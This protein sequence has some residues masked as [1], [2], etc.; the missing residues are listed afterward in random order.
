MIR[1]GIIGSGNIV[2]TRHLP[3]IRSLRA[4]ACV[5]GISDTHRERADELARKYS[6]PYASSNG[7][8]LADIAWIDNVD[9]VVI[10]TPPFSHGSL[11]LQALAAGKHVLVEK[12]F[13]LDLEEG[14]NA[15]GL[16][17]RRNVILAVNHNFQFSRGFTKLRNSLADGALGSLRAVYSVQLSNDQRRLPAWSERLPM[18]L[19]Y[20]ESPHVFYLLRRFTGADPELRSVHYLGPSDAGKATPHL[21]D[22]QLDCGGLPASVHIDFESP[23]C[24]WF[25]AIIGDKGIAYVDLFRDIYAYLPSDGQHLM[26]EVLA[27]SSLATFQHWL[28]FVQNGLSYVR[29]RLYYGFDVVYDNFLSAVESGNEAPVALHSG[30]DGLAVN[31]LQHAVINESLR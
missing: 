2:R 24:E 4:R 5:V 27:T 12:P 8:T 26:R 28:G 22:V 10:A 23:I 7:Q 30:A 25:F 1:L 3:A 14:R 31:E 16:A 19:F 15:I 21:L 11:V 9:A 13:V 29:H 17:R 20:D 6:I 18:G